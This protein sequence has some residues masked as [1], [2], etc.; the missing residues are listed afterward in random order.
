LS[1]DSMAIQNHCSHFARRNFFDLC[2]WLTVLHRKI[3][4]G[5][6]RGRQLSRKQRNTVHM[7]H[8]SICHN[9]YQFPQQLLTAF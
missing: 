9:N 7:Q 1:S 6:K 4:T 3:E 5:L 2:L 8:L